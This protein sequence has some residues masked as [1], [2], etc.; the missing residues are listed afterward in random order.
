[1]TLSPAKSTGWQKKTAKRRGRKKKKK[2]K[3]INPNQNPK[4]KKA[5]EIGKPRKYRTNPYL[6]PSALFRL[7]I[8]DSPAAN[9]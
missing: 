6:F 2:K 7:T 8:A 1:V 4:V 5:C 9:H 3:S